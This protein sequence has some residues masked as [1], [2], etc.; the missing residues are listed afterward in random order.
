MTINKNLPKNNPLNIRGKRQ[1][2]VLLAFAIFIIF[3][4]SAGISALV[5]KNTSQSVVHTV[6]IGAPGKQGPPGPQG[7]KGP[8]GKQGI[9][10]PISK[11]TEVDDVWTFLNQY[12]IPTVGKLIIKSR[13]PNPPG[14]VG[15]TGPAGP[16]GLPGADG[17][18]GKIGPQGEKGPQGRSGKS[19]YDTWKTIE[20]NAKKTPADFFNFLKTGN[21]KSNR[22]FLEEHEAL[23]QRFENLSQIFEA[24]IIRNRERIKA[25]EKQ[26]GLNNKSL[27]PL[28]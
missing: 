25:I 28:P 8:P 24:N 2:L 20:G 6:K 10:G 14:P 1:R 13:S 3:G 16:Q 7:P 26:I 19:L 18:D 15:P 12:L 22:I 23:K 11:N 9:P 17:L 5:A 27:F 4:A 21:F